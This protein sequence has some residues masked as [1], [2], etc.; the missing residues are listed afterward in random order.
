VQ[1]K[2]PA[3]SEGDGPGALPILTFV[4]TL[5][6]FGLAPPPETGMVFCSLSSRKTMKNKAFQQSF[7]GDCALSS[8]VEHFLH[9]EGVA[10]SNPAARTIHPAIPKL[11]IRRPKRMRVPLI[12]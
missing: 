4:L 10:G 12:R 3:T 8:A 2:K 1:S 11:E 9:T 7:K 6:F 5:R